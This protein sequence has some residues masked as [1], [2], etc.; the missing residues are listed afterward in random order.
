MAREHILFVDDEVAVLGGIERLLHRYH[1]RW[2]MTYIEQSAAAWRA[3]QRQGFDAV[4]TDVRMPGMNGLELL[5]RIRN[6]DQTRGVP[7]VVLTGMSDRDLKRQALL[8]GA[9]DLLKKPV[10]PDDLVARLENVLRQKSYVDSLQQINTAL[11][12]QVQQQ[13]RQLTRSRFELVACLGRVAEQHDEQ[14]SNHV[15][16]VALYSGVIAMALGLSGGILEMLLLAAPLHDIGK[17]GIPRAILSKPG[18]LCPSEWAV[19]RRHCEIGEWIL[20]GQSPRFDRLLSLSPQVAELSNVDEPVLKTA[21]RIA[22]CHHE[23]WDGSGYPQHLRGAQIP[24][25]ARIVAVADAF[26]ALTSP[27]P[28]RDSCREAEAV[29]ILRASTGSHFDPE[30]YAA[31]EA[32][33]PSICSIRQRYGDGQRLPD[34]AEEILL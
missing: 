28:Y 3:L 33:L 14:I 13:N 32:A 30:S 34:D 7:V 20:R 23:K 21:A 4:V 16:R 26:D 24:W 29:D 6:T 9:T 22:L 5:E 18:P 2:E 25:E 1:D 15:V 11:S 12:A 19:M 8:L 10:D 17:I 31:F 27:R